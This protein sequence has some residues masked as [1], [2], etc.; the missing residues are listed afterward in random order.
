MEPW[1]SA[2]S[3]E[4]SGEK[5]TAPANR[6]TPSFS[7]RTAYAAPPSTT[8]Y[9]RL[10]TSQTAGRRRRGERSQNFKDEA[11]GKPRQRHCCV[12]TAGL[13]REA[14]RLALGARP[15]PT[16]TRSAHRGAVGVTGGGAGRGSAAEP[17]RREQR[18]GVPA[19][20]PAGRRGGR[21]APPRR[22]QDGGGLR[23]QRHEEPA[24][25]PAVGAAAGEGGRLARRGAVGAE[26]E[27][28]GGA[29]APAPAAA[30][31]GRPALAP[32]AAA[33]GGGAVGDGGRAVAPGRGG[34]GRG[35]HGEA[36]LEAEGVGA[37]EQEVPGAA[38]LVRAGRRDLGRGAVGRG[39]RDRVEEEEVVEAGPHPPGRAV[40]RRRDGRRERD[41]GAAERA[42]GVRAEPDVD[43][44]GVEGVRAQRQRAE[45]V[46]VRELEQ[47]HGA[48]PG[49][50]RPARRRGREVLRRGERLD[51][52]IVEAAVGREGVVVVVVGGEGREGAVP[53]ARG[54]GG[55]GAAA[56]GH[57]QPQPAPAPPPPRRAE[58]PAHQ[59]R[60][61]HHQQRRAHH[62]Q[63]RD[64]RRA[65]APAR[66]PP[67]ARERRRRRGRLRR[68]T[69]TR[70]RRRAWGGRER[71]RVGRRRRMGVAR[72]RRGGRSWRLRRGRVPRP[73][74]RAHGGLAAVSAC[75][76]VCRCGGGQCAGGGG[77]ERMA[78]R[79]EL[80]LLLL[81][82]RLLLLLLLLLVGV[83]KQRRGMMRVVEC[84]GGVL[85]HLLSH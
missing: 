63:H 85:A 55:E 60:V 57:E 14:T 48:L 44:V 66:P 29:P 41:G 56:R 9:T 52:G 18:L 28:A 76:W 3:D 72:G 74:G 45:L 46:A 16:A 36:A 61:Q 32:E 64:E 35:L 12:E 80:L 13:L 59:A 26:G 19:P 8:M 23:R 37:L 75:L 30:E 62:R 40:E 25:G 65:Q 68:G 83:S 50:P 34:R 17:V 42:G 24:P 73:A 1:S 82:L 31:R 15:P 58:H 33:A 27:D 43:A 84:T 69:C 47:A 54:G 10:V 77:G 20:E 4:P 6:R 67:A 70:A 22:G 53:A 7:D 79:Q 5:T 38:E 11:G 78:R 49:R 39:R 81:R 2:P 51:G 21:A 71:R